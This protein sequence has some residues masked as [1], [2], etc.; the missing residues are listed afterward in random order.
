MCDISLHPI[1]LPAPNGK[2]LYKSVVSVSNSMERMVG[3]QHHTAAG[4]LENGI[5]GQY[6]WQNRSTK[7]WWRIF[8][9]G[10]KKKK[11]RLASQ[12]KY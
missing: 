4:H 12:G 7:S 2:I 8:F 6:L 5:C 3:D 11:K 9:S 10:A 1:I